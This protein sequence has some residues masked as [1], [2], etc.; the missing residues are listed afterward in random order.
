MTPDICPC[1]ASPT[2]PAT[3]F[4]AW[5]SHPGIGRS[6]SHS[7]FIGRSDLC[8]I[9]TPRFDLCLQSGG[10]HILV[11]AGSE[12]AADQTALTFSD[13]QTLISDW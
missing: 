2:Y 8:A 11:D 9:L 5:Y 1:A 12:G 3:T 7:T 6:S 13:N 4:P 10:E